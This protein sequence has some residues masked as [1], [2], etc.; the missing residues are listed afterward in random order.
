MLN[1]R[2]ISLTAGMVAAA[3]LTAGALISS[4]AHAEAAIGE[5]APAFTGLTSSGETISLDDFAGKTVVLEWT[6]DGCPFVKKHYAEPPENM[7]GMQRDTAEDEIVW[8]SVISSAPG[9]QGY[10]DAERANEL[11]TSRGAAPAYVIL[12]PEGEMGRAYDAKTTPHMYV[13]D[14]DGM[15]QYQGAIDSISS[16]RVGD[17]EKADN[18]VTAAL[19]DLAAGQP[20]QTASTKAYGCSVK[21]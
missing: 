11:T 14:G 17:I 21:Y 19:D 10:A 1:R 2:P 12:D 9:K 3:A 15:L 20:V 18:Y 8:I 5:A 16:A 13:I 4:S 6:N 7:Q